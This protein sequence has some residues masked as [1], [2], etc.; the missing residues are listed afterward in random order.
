[1]QGRDKIYSLSY[2]IHETKSNA[3]GGMLDNWRQFNTEVYLYK[4]ASKA[5]LAHT[6]NS[7]TLQIQIPKSASFPNDALQGQHK[8]TLQA[9]RI[10][11]TC[12]YS[13]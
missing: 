6:F 10:L 11:C 12:K 1:M 4:V 5:Y 3:K 8:S 2:V 13:S 7:F 9:E